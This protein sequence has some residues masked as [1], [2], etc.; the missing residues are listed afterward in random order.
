MKGPGQT[1]LTFWAMVWFALR[2]SC[3]EKMQPVFKFLHSWRT[4]AEEPL[5]I[6]Q[7]RPT[8][9]QGPHSLAIFARGE[10]G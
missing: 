9:S 2:P 8:G 4:R 5:S 1:H 10:A 3:L 6:H 7:K